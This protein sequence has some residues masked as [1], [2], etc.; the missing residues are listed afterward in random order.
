V[1]GVADGLPDDTPPGPPDADPDADGVGV[2]VGVPLGVGVGVGEPAVGLDV[3]LEVGVGLGLG[4]P[5]RVPVPDRV[6]TAPEGERTIRADHGST[7]AL[8]SSTLTSTVSCAP[9]ASVPPSRLSRSQGASVLAVHISAPPPVLVRVITVRS[10]DSAACTWSCPG[11]VPPPE[12]PPAA[13]PGAELADGLGEVMVKPMFSPRCPPPAVVTP[14]EGGAPAV[15][16]GSPAP[17]GVAPG[18][19]EAPSVTRTEVT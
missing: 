15:P 7:G 6:T 5:R 3:G 8:D 16:L 11:D 4:A 17:G 1:T 10:P 18:A 2:G 14:A 13:P 12:P 19:P 9:G